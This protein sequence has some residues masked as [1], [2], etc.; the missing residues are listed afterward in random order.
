MLTVVLLVCCWVLLVCWCA[1]D[2]G[3]GASHN[4]GPSRPNVAKSGAFRLDLG[5]SARMVEKKRLGEDLSGVNT[6][7]F[8]TGEGLSEVWNG[9]LAAG[10]DLSKVWNRVFLREG[11]IPRF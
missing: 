3:A 9:T 7:P 1:A 10:E 5:D 4:Q 11:A 2:A 6:R 8:V